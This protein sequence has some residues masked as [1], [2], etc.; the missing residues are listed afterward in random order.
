MPRKF[1]KFCGIWG[2][3]ASWLFAICNYEA[4]ETSFG[5]IEPPWAKWEPLCRRWVGNLHN[6]NLTKSFNIR[7]LS[8]SRF[9]HN[10][11]ILRHF[12]NFWARDFIFW[13]LGLLPCN[14]EG[15]FSKLVKIL[16]LARPGFP[17]WWAES[18]PPPPWQPGE[19]YPV[20]NRVKTKIVWS[21]Q[22][23]FVPVN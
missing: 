13:I 10:F 7:N 1:R 21:F 4:I 18:A 19:K 15:V 8:I 20:A 11:S 5:K 14:I 16:K 23:H 3:G 9:R 12:V 2:L 22:F 17:K 6:A